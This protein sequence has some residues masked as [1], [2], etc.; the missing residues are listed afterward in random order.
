[1]TRSVIAVGVDDSESSHQALAWA[2]HEALRRGSTL[3]L[4][5]TW[6]LDHSTIGPNHSGPAEGQ[7]L[8]QE[9]EAVQ[10]R[11]V[12]A[13]LADMDPCPEVAHVVV[14]ASAADA[15]LAASAEADLIVVGTHARGAV[16]TFLFG[17]VSQ[18]LIK[19]SRCPV[20][21]IPPSATDGAAADE[22]DAG[23]A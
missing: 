11:A 5:T 12:A 17:S 14:Q 13:V 1:M 9:A 23:D 10:T 2:A 3:E 22:L 19:S 8:E 16:R 20:V 15:L 4:V 6:G 18:T 21:V 7:S